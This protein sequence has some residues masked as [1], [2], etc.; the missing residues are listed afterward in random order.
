MLIRPVERG[1]EPVLTPSARF[2]HAPSCAVFV[3]GA[4]GVNTNPDYPMTL[5]VSPWFWRRLLEGSRLHRLLPQSRLI[6]SLPGESPVEAKEGFIGEVAELFGL[7]RD[8]I[9]IITEALTTADEARLANDHLSDDEP[10]FLVT[11]ALHMRRAQQIF[12]D[13]GIAV[14]PAPC[15]FSK[16]E[17]PDDPITILD[18]VPSAGNLGATRGGIHE[19]LGYL[20]QKI[21]PGREREE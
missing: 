12:E 7:D 1:F 14:T 6:V 2:Q 16:P 5:R 17:N 19:A 3:L 18:F 20:W 15:G 21:T 4:G 11:E 8:R 10:C 13:A 9:V